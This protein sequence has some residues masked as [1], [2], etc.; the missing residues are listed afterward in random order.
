MN[1]KRVLLTL[2]FGFGLDNSICYGQKL[3]HPSHAKLNHQSK[4][5]THVNKLDSAKFILDAKRLIAGTWEGKYG[6]TKVTMCFN[7]D[8]TAYSIYS[9]NDK[10]N[11]FNYRFL[12]PHLLEFS[13]KDKRRTGRYYVQKLTESNL[14]FIVY[15]IKEEYP[16]SI[17][18][19]EAIDFVKQ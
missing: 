11:P 8:G 10:K 18:I 13:G 1:M 16:E 15:P 17:L 14:H 7:P 19:I 9:S 2:L 5:I 12:T 3:K 4:T 6:N